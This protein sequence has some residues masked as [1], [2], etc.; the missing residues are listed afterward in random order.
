MSGQAGLAF[1]PFCQHALLP[2][3]RWPSRYCLGTTADGRVIYSVLRRLRPE[4]R[5]ARGEHIRWG[6]PDVYVPAVAGLSRGLPVFLDVRVVR[7]DSS[8]RAEA[9]TPVAD[10]LREA[11]DSR[12]ALLLSSTPAANRTT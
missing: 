8:K 9:N 4:R 7:G 10:T 1:R 3:G 6:N 11:A 2:E 12:R 5:D